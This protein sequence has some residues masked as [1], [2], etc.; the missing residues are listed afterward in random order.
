MTAPGDDHDDGEE[1]S[2]PPDPVDRAWRHPSELAAARRA[3]LP[4][5][6][7]SFISRHRPAL[8]GATGA[9][10]AAGGVVVG[11]TVLR[12]DPTPGTGLL[13]VQ[14]AATSAPVAASPTT[15]RISTAA[16]LDTVAPADDGPTTS[17]GDALTTE[18]TDAPV[19][20]LSPDVRSGMVHVRL[21]DHTAATAVQVSRDRVVLIQPEV[22]ARPG[23][24]IDVDGTGPLVVLSVDHGSGITVLAGSVG[25]P[26]PTTGLDIGDTVAI[27]GADGLDV[28][29]VIERDR[30]MDGLHGPL[31]GLV[32]TNIALDPDVDTAPGGRL[33]LDADGRVVA[34]TVTTRHR[35]V[36]AIPFDDVVSSLRW[37]D[38][39]PEIGCTVELADGRLIVVA[40][41]D[42][43]PTGRAGLRI[44]D[45]I[46]RVNGREV[47]HADD[48][49]DAL[50]D[51]DEDGLEV[52]VRRDT[53]GAKVTRHRLR[54]ELPM[55]DA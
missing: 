24:T 39:T 5:P 12:A 41:D 22:V 38:A 16:P 28:G 47:H 51:R 7:T 42:D 46:V 31:D 48:L 45:R 25:E 10:I 15:V 33:L 44:G 43:G 19:V 17:Q 29:T 3:L 18:V 32:L 30:T 1:F 40:V 36:A 4:P 27:A 9:A 35:L 21:D 2:L 34:L 14:A 26:I 55:L 8:I 49:D 6:R 13:G 37:A 54:V 20:S 52:V 11:L 50:L 23:R 53:G